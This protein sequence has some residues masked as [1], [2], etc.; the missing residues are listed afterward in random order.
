M[1]KT[2]FFLFSLFMLL[3]TPL[4]GETLWGESESEAVNINAESA[5]LALRRTGHLLL[6]AEKDSA[7]TIPPVKQLDPQTFVLTLHAGFD[8]DL[9]PGILRESLALR[10][11]T[12]DY[13]VLVFDC[14]TDTLIL[15]YFYMSQTPDDLLPCVGRNLIRGCSYIK[16]VFQPDTKTANGKQILTTLIIVTVVL[17]GLIFFRSYKQPSPVREDE[18]ATT[19]GFR[20]SATELDQPNLK[21]VVAGT[22]RE[23]TFREAKLLHYFF[24][25]PNELLERDRIQKNVWEDEGIIV[26]RSLDVFVSRLRKILAEDQGLRIVNVRGVGYRLVVG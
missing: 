8:Y 21:V 7:T 1:V 11:I 22:E 6:L 14:V 3:Q 2:H 23:L 26:D 15:G 10:N 5:N 4:A 12:A 20:L 18:P 16:V 19:S 24:Q 25:Y 9:L 13:E 17:A